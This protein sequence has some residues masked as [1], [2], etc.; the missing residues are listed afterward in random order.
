MQPVTVRTTCPICR[1]VF[2]RQVMRCPLDGALLQPLPQDPLVGEVL[3]GRYAVEYVA[4]D[5]AVARTYL[6]TD[7]RTG[8]RCAVRVMYGDFAAIERHRRRFAR[9]A[10]IGRRLCHPNVLAVID[11]GETTGALPFLVTVH[12]RGE[13]LAAVIARDAPLGRARAVRLVRDLAA[14]LGHLHERGFV[15]RGIT[16]D[17]VLVTHSGDVEEAILTDLS[18]AFAVGDRDQDDLGR[19]TR[20]GRVVGAPAYLSPEQGGG[21][22]CDQRADLYSLGVLFYELLAGKAPFDG[23]ALVVAG[24]HLAE[25]PPALA[26]RVPGLQ[27]DRALESIVMR[28]LEKDPARRYQSVADL[29]G[30]LGQPTLA[31][32]PPAAGTP[33]QERKAHE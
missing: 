30:S 31:R 26:E 9:E 21:G 6:A 23:P 18:A 29:L 3:G 27:V 14:G 5:G 10:E 32:E 20:P 2:R 7:Q 17:A 33:A 15:H 13:P 4:G 11:S 8:E 24:R 25:A 16:A 22:A 19:L 1:A 12:L 28:L